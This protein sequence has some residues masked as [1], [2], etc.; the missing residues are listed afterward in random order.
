M[1]IMPTTT[2]GNYVIEVLM[3]TTKGNHIT[4]FKYIK[5]ICCIPEIYTMLGVKYKT[6]RLP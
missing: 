2:N 4:K 3:I 1:L 5:L 6:Y